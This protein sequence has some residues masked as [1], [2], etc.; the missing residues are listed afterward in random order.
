[1]TKKMV[2]DK[3]GIRIKIN[4]KEAGRTVSGK[5]RESIAT[6]TGT[7][8]ADFGYETRKRGEECSKW[9]PEMSTRANGV[10]EKNMAWED[11]PSQT[12]ITT[13]ANSLRATVAVEENTP[14]LME[15]FTKGNGRRIK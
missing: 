11:I 2:K 6:T 9:K 15:V 3:C 14:G 8:I 12:K 10:M 1:M 13:K 7:T 4:M 5:G